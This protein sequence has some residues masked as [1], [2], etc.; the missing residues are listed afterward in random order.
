VQARTKIPME[1]NKPID[2]DFT[3]LIQEFVQTRLSWPDDDF[4]C[5]LIFRSP[6]LDR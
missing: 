1:E 4:I 2:R 3:P 6:F 5:G